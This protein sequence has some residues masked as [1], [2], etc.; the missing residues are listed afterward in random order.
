MPV[1]RSLPWSGREVPHGILDLGRGCD[2]R[3]TACYNTAAPGFRSL[4]ELERDLEALARLRRLHTV[5]L[6]GGEPLLHPALAQLVRMVKARVPRCTMLTNGQRLDDRRCAEL[7]AAGL[8][9]CFLHVDA[10]QRRT[11]LRA[12]AGTEGL[13]ALRRTLARRC[14]AHGIDAGLEITVYRSRSG[15]LARAVDLVTG[16]PALRYLLATLCC[17]IDGFSGLRGDLGRGFRAGFQPG[18]LAGEV[19]GTRDARALLARHGMSPLSY[20]GSSTG[21]DGPRWLTYGRLV[22]HRDDGSRWRDL[23]PGLAGVVLPRLVRWLTGR[24]PFYLPRDPWRARLASAVMPGRGGTVVDKWFVIQHGP[25]PGRDGGVVT[26]AGCPDAVAR[27][28]R[29]VPVCLSDRWTGA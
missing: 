20:L 12:E 5:T 16:E 14:A 19:L 13:D 27:Q 9:A 2:C 7:A 28:G 21:R 18:I 3:C 25:Q 23:R 1:P 17:D 26:C 29:L 24:Y 10:G 8:D 15:E 4:A 11:D 6:M 22:R